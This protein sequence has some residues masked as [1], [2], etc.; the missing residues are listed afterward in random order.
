M[1]LGA[2]HKNV[3]ARVA[4]IEADATFF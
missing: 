3:S 2:L 4:L 1:R